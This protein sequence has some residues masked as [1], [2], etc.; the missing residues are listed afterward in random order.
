[1]K[2]ILIIVGLLNPELSHLTRKIM[3]NRELKT[4]LKNKNQKLKQENMKIC[5]TEENAFGKDMVPVQ[6]SLN[7]QEDQILTLV[8][9]DK[10][11]STKDCNEQINARI[12][13]NQI[14]V[15]LPISWTNKEYLLPVVTL[16]VLFIASITINCVLCLRPVARTG[17]RR[18]DNF[19]L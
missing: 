18:Q 3:S 14:A 2:I 11:N 8:M 6:T 9:F 10:A 15:L 17:P 16:F 19:E 7:L 13:E 4:F 5:V 12:Q 1:M